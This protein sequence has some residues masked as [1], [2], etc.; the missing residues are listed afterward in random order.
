MRSFKNLKCIVFS[1]K[2]RSVFLKAMWLV[3]VAFLPMLLVHCAPQDQVNMLERRINSLSAENRSFSNQINF[4][5]QEVAEL[6]KITQKVGKQDIAAVRSRQAELVNRMDELQAEL[7]RLNGLIDQIGH[8][9]AQEEEATLRFKEDLKKQVENLREEVKLLQAST[10]VT[11]EVEQARKNA[12]QGAVDLY[13]QALDLIKQKKY[14]DAKKTLRTYI[15]KHPHGKRVANAYFWMGECEYNIQRFEEAILEYQKV[16]SRYPKSNKV[17]DSL[18]K[19][20]I[21]FAKLGDNES[22][23]IVLNKLIKKYPKSPQVS[24]AKKKLARLK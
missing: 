14:K 2:S 6:K 15:E 10:K 20:G 11:K 23:K 7:L 16:I 18:L 3:V 5:K 24:V 17:P 13:Q 8:K 1:E 21:A 19:Q 4:L 22:A 12:A 9:S